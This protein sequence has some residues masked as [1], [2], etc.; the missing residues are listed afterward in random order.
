MTAWHGARA[1]RWSYLLLD[2]E[3]RPLGTLDGVLGGSVEV[4]ALS[5]LGGSGSLTVDERGQT[6]D[7]MSHRVQ[8]IYDP[9]IR[10]VAA[11]PVAT[12]MF[13]SP[14]MRQTDTTRTYA[15]TLL[16]KMAVIDEDTVE[17]SLSL[18]AG[19]AIIP[20]VV[21]L[22]ESTGETRTAV[23][24]SAA[25][26]SNPLVWE[27][28]E[29]KLS[30]INDLLAAAGYWSLWCDGSGQFR[31]EPYV[32]PDARPTAYEF[33]DGETAI[34]TP[35]WGREQNLS[36]VPNKFV[37]V[38]QGSDETPP[39]IGVATNED[40]DSPYS[41]QSR[42]RWITSVDEGVEGD[43]QAVFDQLAR[44]RLWDAMS[45][46][47]KLTAEHAVIP[48]EPNQAISFTDHG[49]T[50]RATIQRLS[51]EFTFDADCKAEWRE[52]A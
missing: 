38:G 46:V 29:S 17:T 43:S 30:I 45:P 13:T 14:Q 1:P 27:A 50:V 5:R 42:G 52:I 44:R 28:G 35:E 10:D 37:V 34:H 9:G 7:W 26:L 19:T 25:T 15:V 3:D 47:A 24:A 49:E 20:A 32:D 36:S 23:T 40:P 6:I 48:L 11:W 18:A 51:Y 39:L 22:I 21:N 31:V 2:R 8:C 16:S 4:A 12:M 33:I 41:Y